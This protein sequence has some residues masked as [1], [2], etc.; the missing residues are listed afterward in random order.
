[1]FEYVRLSILYMTYKIPAKKMLKKYIKDFEVQE[2][3]P[4]FTIN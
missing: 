2:K 1:M 4:M 3:V